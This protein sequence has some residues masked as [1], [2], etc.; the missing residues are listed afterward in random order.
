MNK[1][2]IV[3][4]LSTI[5][6]L[7]IAGG[8]GGAFAWYQFNSQV[9]TA[10]IGQSVADTGL[11]Q[12]GYSA[13]GNQEDA[14]WGRNY[15]IPNTNDLV[16]VTFGQ[17]GDNNVLPSTAYGYPEAG[18]QSGSDYTKGWQ[19]VENKHGYYQYSIYLRALVTDPAAQA[20][21][22][23]QIAA[24]YKLAKKDVY[25]SDI[26]LQGLGDNAQG[27]LITNAI[28]VHIDVNGGK[29]MLIANK[30]VTNLPLF[31]KLDLDGDGYNDKYDV[32]PWDENYNNELTYGISGQYQSALAAA[33]VKKSPDTN[34]LYPE[35]DDDNPDPKLICTTSDGV[36]MT[37]ITITVWLEGWQVLKN[38]TD[39]DNL[40]ATWNPVMNAGDEKEI[41]VG[42]VFDA[43]RNI[44]G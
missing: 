28:R 13:T 1:K 16:P 20:V 30:T 7:S 29:K 32:M 26:V 14:Q 15:V 34:G 39:N 3:P 25:L 27:T 44:I 9:M 18:G 8:L 31:G 6:G 33:D 19:V 24:G 2:L 40:S 36:N 4:F 23:D 35:H 42:L 22:A 37:K 21:P 41:H 10:F 12:I 11:L 17:L 38:N 5:I 43:G